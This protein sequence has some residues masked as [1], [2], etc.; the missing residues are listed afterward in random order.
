[1]AIA[2]LFFKKENAISTVEIDAVINEGASA[3]VR[4]TE[5]PVENGANMNDHVIIEPKT[6]F[7]SGV[8]SNISSTFIGQIGNVV[9]SLGKDQTKA[10]E[11]WDALL[12]LQAERQPFDLVQGLKTYPNVILLSIAEAQDKDTSNALFF[13]ATMKEVIFPGTQVITPDQFNESNIADKMVPPVNGGL[14]QLGTIL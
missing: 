12:E 5:N 11:A 10:Q 13:N 2:Q 7:V 14:K 6:F 3:S 9:S 1:M 8:V 4:L